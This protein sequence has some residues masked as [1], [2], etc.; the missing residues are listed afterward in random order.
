MSRSWPL[1]AR[2]ERPVF[3]PV[4]MPW[5]LMKELLNIPGV[6]VAPGGLA[7]TWDVA[8]FL[9]ARLKVPCPDPPSEQFLPNE[10]LEQEVRE[11]PG[12]ERF[13][14]LGLSNKARDYQKDGAIFLARRAYAMNADPMRCVAGDTE[15]I[16]NRGGAARRITMRELVAKFND[17]GNGGKRWDR[18]IE[19][20]VAAFDEVAS[21]IKN[22]VTAAHA[23][24][25][26]SAWRL[27]TIDGHEIVTSAEHQFRTPD[28]YV[29]LQDLRPGELVLVRGR[30]VAAPTGPRANPYRVRSVKNHPFAR[31][32]DVEREA[33]PTERVHHVLVHRLIYEAVHL[34]G[35]DVEDFVARVRCG[36][37]EGLRFLQPDEHIHHRDEDPRNNNPANLVKMAQAEHSRQH[38]IDGAFRH[39]LWSALSCEIAKIE[40]ADPVEMFDLEMADPYRNYIANGIV[41]H[42]SGKSIQSLMASV[43]VD[44]KRVLITA[45]SLA[46][47][48][49]ADEVAK[50][51]GEE[52]VICEGRG[53]STVRVYCKTC[54]ARGTVNGNRCPDCRMRNGSARGYRLV[55]GPSW[56]VTSVPNT[57]PVAFVCRKHPEIEHVVA[58]LD[59]VETTKCAK[60]TAELHATIEKARYVIV[61]YD[62]LIAQQHNDKSGR[63]FLR[64]HLRGWA[65]A[66]AH[67]AFDLCIADEFH[68]LRGWSPAAAKAGTGRREKWIAV[69]ENVPQVWG[70]TGTPVF[71]F[72]RDL[73][74]QF[75]ALSKGAM[76]GNNARLPFTFHAHYCEGFKD[77]YGWK[78]D[79]RSY[80]AETELPQRLS[81]VKIQRKR[82]E[83]LSSLPPKIRQMIRVDPSKQHVVP[84]LTG[85]AEPTGKIAKA[86]TAT[87]AD[88]MD[89]I[90]EN[91]VSELAQGN[92][93][94]VF[95][96][97]KPSAEK[98]AAK[99]AAVC[100]LKENVT[101][102]R[103]VNVRAWR[104]HGEVS[105]QTRFDMSRAFR[106][107]SGAGVF[108][109]TIDS[110][111]V[112]V[113]LKGAASVHFAEL[114]WQPAALLQAEDRPYE[115]ETNGLS[116]VYYIVRGSIDEHVEHVVLPKVETMS[117]LVQEKGAAE[118]KNVMSVS[119]NQTLDE[120]IAALTAGIDPADFADYD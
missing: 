116:I 77:E 14:A 81:V 18:R 9:A 105:A 26:K 53:G 114:H 61:N 89:V 118:L 17:E 35:M 13:R 108:V 102:M 73:W 80:A 95:T 91:V 29:R 72:T 82:E 31:I 54:M 25:L 16:V 98:L 6:V 32:Y 107:H 23:V 39:V 88:K 106:E 1:G 22:R 27:T 24:G 59:E 64:P 87:L 19:T 52:A 10:V 57:E 92:K 93:V 96:L 21:C 74:S 55:D 94:V 41:V 37:L 42:N 15:L 40:E 109:A 11:M 36:E 104:A 97:M 63:V 84:T 33:R 113:S 34:N 79:G 86:M 112:A 49:W 70:L 3:F 45:P 90:V 30:P 28:G 75:D 101:R 5:D 38:A 44:A 115:V 68:L 99:I 78:A 110:V 4:S 51:I 111:Q 69:T 46:K 67:H 65:P 117:R 103:E 12:L 2:G 83:I 7:C 120:L 60:C 20:Y 100:A 48:V 85:A 50:W 71:G 66:L 62:I 43:L 119:S 47:W 76:T 8:P 56:A 58:T